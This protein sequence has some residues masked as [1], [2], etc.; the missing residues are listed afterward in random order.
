MNIRQFFKG[1][2]LHII[3][4]TITLL[5]ISTW[6]LTTYFL[7]EVWS[8]VRGPSEILAVIMI[9][10]ALYITFLMSMRAWELA[11]DRI[12]VPKRY[13]GCVIDFIEGR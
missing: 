13:G 3:A 11:L 7:Y 1:A 5:S 6:A 12:L 8:I 4:I 9:A 2:L 10:S